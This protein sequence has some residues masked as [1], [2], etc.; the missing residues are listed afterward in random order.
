MCKVIGRAARDRQHVGSVLS[1][2]GSWETRQAAQTAIGQLL[3]NTSRRIQ[4]QWWKWSLSRQ[5][6]RTGVQSKTVPIWKL[7]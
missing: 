1:F 7:G 3:V 5:S 6:D 2:G 4:G